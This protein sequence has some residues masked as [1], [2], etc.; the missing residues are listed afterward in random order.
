MLGA[1]GE[2]WP[3]DIFA[4]GAGVNLRDQNY[5]RLHSLLLFGLAHRPIGNVTKRISLQLD[6]LQKSWGL[7][8]DVT[9]TLSVFTHTSGFCNADSCSNTNSRSSR[10]A[11]CKSPL[12]IGRSSSP[13]PF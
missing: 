10:I 2:V 12:A 3:T 5:L 7:D 9:S 4:A 1:G 8:L 6:A 13:W 11:T